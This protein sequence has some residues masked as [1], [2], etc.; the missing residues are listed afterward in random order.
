MH[1]ATSV[2]VRH[3]DV[4]GGPVN[5]GLGGVSA[6]HSKS[7]VRHVVRGNGFIPPG[8]SWCVAVYRLTRARSSFTPHPDET[9]TGVESALMLAFFLLSLAPWL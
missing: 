1:H 5:T 3:D 7:Q 4:R 8:P 9:N 6:A 2:G